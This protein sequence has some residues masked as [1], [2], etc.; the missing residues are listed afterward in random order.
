[1]TGSLGAILKNEVAVCGG[2]V[3]LRPPAGAVWGMTR[4]L[5]LVEAV[6]LDEDDP[7]CGA[8][9]AIVLRARRRRRRQRRRTGEKT[10]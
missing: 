4:E 2:L 1:M 3:M 6:G 10:S 9:V 8:G 5:E 7:A